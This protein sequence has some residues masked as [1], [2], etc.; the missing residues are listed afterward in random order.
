MRGSF[1]QSIGQRD[2]R[3]SP[4]VPFYHIVRLF[5]EIVQPREERGEQVARFGVCG[6]G[7]AAD[8]VQLK[9]RSWACARLGLHQILPLV[10]FLNRLVRKARVLERLFQR[11]LGLLRCVGQR[12]NLIL[13]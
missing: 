11:Q 10:L 12:G 6:G 13:R 7:V 3:V 2:R 1:P 4:A 5:H 8:Y 9:R